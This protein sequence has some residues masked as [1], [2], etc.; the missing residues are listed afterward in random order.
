MTI[1]SSTVDSGDTSS[2]TSIA[3]TFTSSG[4]TTDFNASDITVSGGVISNFS[5]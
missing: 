3:L 2:D 4:N 1:T 5:G